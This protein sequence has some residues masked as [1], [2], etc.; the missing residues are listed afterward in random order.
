LLQA[1]DPACLCPHNVEGL[2]EGPSLALFRTHSAWDTP[3][4]G[5]EQLERDIVKRCS[6]VPLALK[7]AGGSVQRQERKV[8]WEVPALLFV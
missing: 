1:S 7:I 2:D 5:L 6:G 4:A 3:P 8:M